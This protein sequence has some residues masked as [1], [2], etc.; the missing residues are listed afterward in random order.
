MIMVKQIREEYE[1]RALIEVTPESIADTFG[2][3][4]AATYNRMLSVVRASMNVAIKRGW[5]D[6]GMAD[7]FSK[8]KVPKRSFRWLTRQEFAAVY[9]QL[10]DHLKPMALFAVSTGMRWGNVANLTWDCID[11]AGKLAWIEA[12]DAKARKAI[13]VPLNADALAALAMAGTRKGFVFTLDGAP[14]A[15]PKTG[16]HRAVTRA[17]IPP[18]RWHDLRHTWA[19]WHLQNGT[20]LDAL[21]K[22]GGWASLDQVQIYAHL[23]PSAVAGFADNVQ[24]KHGKAA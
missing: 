18:V 20:P 24:V 11:K 10:A 7:G 12:G 3:R 6:R 4:S 2:D 14:I 16:W 9:A 22:L 23:A 15:S 8:R 17:K 1:N 5:L 21:Q 19:S 13:S